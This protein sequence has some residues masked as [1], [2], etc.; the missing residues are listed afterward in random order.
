LRLSRRQQK[1][2]R[3]N[4]RAKDINNALGTKESLLLIGLIICWT[5]TPSFFEDVRE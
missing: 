2:Q 4:P 5:N 1:C 3:K